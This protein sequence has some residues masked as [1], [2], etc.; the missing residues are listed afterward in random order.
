LEAIK[1]ASAAGRAQTDASLDAE[2]ARLH[3]IDEDLARRKAYRLADDRLERDRAL[4]DAKL[5]QVRMDTDGMLAREREDTGRA[6]EPVTSGVAGVRTTEA[7]IVDAGRTAE[8]AVTDA[9]VEDERELADAAIALSR[10]DHDD[11]PARVMANRLHTDDDLFAER[12]G[13]DVTLAVLGTTKSELALAHLEEA[14]RGEVLAMVTHDLRTPLM[15]IAM[16]AESL[17]VNTREGATR[18]AAEEVSLAAA[19][20]KRLL[21]DLLDVVR[22]DAGMFR[23][24]KRPHEMNAFLAEVMRQYVPL[25]EARGLEL[26]VQAPGDP[27]V[28]SFDHDR[29]VQVLSNLLGNA[30]KFTL[31]G[32]WVRLGVKRHAEEVEFV[33]RDSGPGIPQDHLPHIFERFW[34]MNPTT[35]RGLGLGLNICEKIVVEHGGRIWVESPVGYGATFRFTIPVASPALD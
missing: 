2:R 20:M 34:Q 26:R 18:E 15:V 12:S 1:K 27:F 32:G 9:V 11:D 25:F 24:Q 35:R 21:V 6:W 16:N 33:V 14:R 23:I 22:I 5:L 10:Q 30:M 8:R 17:E 7:K 13:A 31:R 28:V 4:A 29:I 19:R 3:T